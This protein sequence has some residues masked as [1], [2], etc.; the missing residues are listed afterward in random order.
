MAQQLANPTS[1]HEDTGSIAG[2]AQWIKGSGV[3][4]SCGEGRRH[5]SDPTSLWLWCRLGA[6]APIRLLA[7]ERPYAASAALEKTHT[8]KIRKEYD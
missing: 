8:H 5:G 4:V 7:W 1:I 2:L 3:S 6:T